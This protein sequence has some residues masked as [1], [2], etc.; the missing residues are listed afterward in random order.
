MIHCL[1]ID[2]GYLELAYGFCG[3]NP[4]PFPKGSIA[5]QLFKPYEQ[6]VGRGAE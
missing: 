6:T 5:H 2:L 3:L 1:L 4:P